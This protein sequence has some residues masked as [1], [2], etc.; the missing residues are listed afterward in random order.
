M[1]FCLIDVEDARWLEALKTSPHDT[2]HRPEWIRG[3]EPIDGGD[4]RAAVVA[5]GQWRILIPLMR[6]P[7]DQG[8]WDA[9]SP[10]GYAGPI[11]SPGAPAEFI[12]A[13]ISHAVQGL[14]TAGCVS[15]FV[16]L[17]PLLGLPHL[18]AAG[19]LVDHGA[20]ISI[21]LTRSHEAL[22]SETR[23]GHRSDINRARREGVTVHR[24]A[25]E[26]HLGTFVGLYH[27]TM[28]R[29]GAS[30]YYFF[31]EKDVRRLSRMLG[32][33]MQLWLAVAEG[34]VIGG[35]IFLFSSNS[36]IVQYHLSAASQAG[37]ARQPAKLILDDARRF[38][39]DAGFR[40]LHLGGGLGA[41]A[42][43]L[44]R[45]KAGFG[46]D[47]HSFRSWRVITDEG[48][49]RLFCQAQGRHSEAPEGFFPAYRAPLSG[50]DS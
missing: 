30:G 33:A 41:Q 49:Y 50:E 3:H 17:H 44:Y 18:P 19:E 29:V 36:G 5:D 9:A 26:E 42:D 21:D 6:R 1:K 28:R 45:F 24:D 12:E 20:T 47:S 4:A 13:A 48:A 22:W 46:T 14:R 43:S 39:K 34:E 31:A 40:R 38:A 10:Y 11:C 27:D 25:S 37:H 8:Y 7:L 23:K 16:R 32:D 15:L 2:Y 35:A